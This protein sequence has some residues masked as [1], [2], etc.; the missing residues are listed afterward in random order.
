MANYDNL[1]YD[2]E[3]VFAPL[4]AKSEAKYALPPGLLRAIRMQGERSNNN[5]VSPKGAA[6][7]YQFMP[8]SWKRFA[9]AGS[10][11]RDPAAASDAAGAH[12][13]AALDLYNGNVGAAVADYNGGP[14]AARAYMST[15]DPGNAETRGYLQRV[16]GAMGDAPRAASAPTTD[17]LGG[18]Y[19]PVDIAAMPD[20]PSLEVDGFGGDSAQLMS[21]LDNLQLDEQIGRVVDEVLNAR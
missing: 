3:R 2:D 20:E 10:D 17:V 19:T 9:P 14:K 11:R 5:Q 21:D 13:W 7:V 6:G 12:L 4:E 1:R 16:M 8:D 15:G 18:S